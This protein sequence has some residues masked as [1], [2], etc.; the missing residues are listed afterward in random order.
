[1]L[2]NYIWLPCSVNAFQKD[3]KDINQNLQV[4][5]SLTKNISIAYLGILQ[6]PTSSCLVFIKVNKD[7]PFLFQYISEIYFIQRTWKSELPE[8]YQVL[9][10]TEEQ[11]RNVW[12]FLSLC[13]TG[14]LKQET[15]GK[16]SLTKGGWQHKRFSTSLWWFQ[17]MQWS[18]CTKMNTVPLRT[19]TWRSPLLFPTV[20]LGATQLV[21][22][23]IRRKGEIFISPPCV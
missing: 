9:A 1:M 13:K 19:L 21:S 5:N 17:K 16:V 2:L 6:V 7:Q 12:A 11:G 14:I 18:V 15:A 23:L 20:N 3:S 4:E 8:Q 22:L 10:V